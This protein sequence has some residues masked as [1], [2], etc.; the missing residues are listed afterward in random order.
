[1]EQSV[2]KHRHINVR[3]QG[4]TQKKEYNIYNKEKVWNQE[5]AKLLLCI[6]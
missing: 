5:Q 6:S 3:G 1:M 2:P 4:I